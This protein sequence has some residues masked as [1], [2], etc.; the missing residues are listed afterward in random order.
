[1]K[2][3]RALPHFPA[4]TKAPHAFQAVISLPLEWWTVSRFGV[5]PSFRPKPC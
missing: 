1:M 4:L 5:R 3:L 2:L